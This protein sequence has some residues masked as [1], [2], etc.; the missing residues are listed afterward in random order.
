M[1]DPDNPFSWT[2]AEK[3]DN[4]E[5]RTFYL[6]KSM[7]YIQDDLPSTNCILEET[8]GKMPNLLNGHFEGGKLV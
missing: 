7:K 3:T 1:L 4:V 5:G 2:H 8:V 6:N